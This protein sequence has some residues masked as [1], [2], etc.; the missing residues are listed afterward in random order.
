MTGLPAPTR[1]FPSA[2][3]WWP[4]TSPSWW[5][6]LFG[7]SRPSRWRRPR[8]RPPTCP[9]TTGG[10]ATEL[11]YTS[12]PAA[13]ALT[14]RPGGSSS[15]AGSGRRVPHASC[16]PRRRDAVTMRKRRV[17]DPGMM[18]YSA[19]AVVPCD[20]P[21][22]VLRPGVVEVTGSRSPTWV[23]PAPA[24]PDGDGAR[25]PGPRGT[26]PRT[27]QR[28]LPLAHDPVPG[29]GREPAARPVA[30]RGALA[31]GGPP[32]RPTTSTGA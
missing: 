31:P 27:G 25:G 7:R 23:R 30:Q 2:W 14:G 26:P 9:S 22:R 21:G 6:R 4:P 18:R 29:V 13:E 16:G 15:R 12:R 11:G 19:D 20:R 1:Q 24:R 5:G 17:G 8:C 28:P 32:H 10:P 3:P